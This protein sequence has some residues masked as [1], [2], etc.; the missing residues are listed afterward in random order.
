MD[1]KQLNY[2]YQ[3][4]NLQMKCVDRPVTPANERAR[5]GGSQ[6]QGQAEHTM[7]SKLA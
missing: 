4:N 2:G 3:N 6:D 7:S 5:T 1:M